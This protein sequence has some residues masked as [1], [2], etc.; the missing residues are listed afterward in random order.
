MF[1]K[2]IPTKPS[3]VA[4]RIKIIFQNLMA[5]TM[6]TSENINDAMADKAI[7]ITIIGETIPADTAASPRTIA[8]KIERA[9]PAK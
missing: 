1:A 6:P 8:P 3:N 9:V 5:L 4:N 2:N 7:I